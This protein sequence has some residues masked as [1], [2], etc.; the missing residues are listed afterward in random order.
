MDDDT[1]AGV[2]GHRIY[3]LGNGNGFSNREVVE[4]VREVT[5]QPVPVEIAPRRDGDPAALVAPSDKARAEL[6]WTP[7]SPNLADIVADA[8]EFNRRELH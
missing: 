4:V 2:P 7:A 1:G 5:G 8:W 6:G 3:N